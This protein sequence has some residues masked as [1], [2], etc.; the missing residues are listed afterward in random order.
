[1]SRLPPRSDV[2][3]AARS[4]AKPFRPS[5]EASCGKLPPPG[6][7]TWGRHLPTISRKIRVCDNW[8]YHRT[9]H[10]W[11]KCYR[12]FFLCRPHFFV[13]VHHF[14]DSLRAA[15]GFLLGVA[16]QSAD[17]MRRERH[18][19]PLILVLS[20]FQP[21]TP[22][23]FVRAGH[24]HETSITDFSPDVGQP[25]HEGKLDGADLPQQAKHQSCQQ[26]Q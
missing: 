25:Q 14:R 4:Y 21:A 10:G 11:N 20:G 18:R 7:R 8:H 16:L 1:M 2:R 3:P 12:L 5:V 24:W 17:D 22:H 13:T 6:K 23:M 9:P 19:K 26:W 15:E